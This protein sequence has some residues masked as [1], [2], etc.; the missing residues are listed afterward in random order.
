MLQLFNCLGP[1]IGRRVS[2][3]DYPSACNSVEKLLVHS[4]LAE[5]GR[6]F[7]L[8]TALRDAGEP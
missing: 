5:D 4:Q 8:Q 3:T 7:K 1:Y 6:L 2:Q